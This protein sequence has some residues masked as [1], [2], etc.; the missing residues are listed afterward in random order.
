[1]SK[2]YFSLFGIIFIL[3]ILSCGRNIQNQVVTNNF[4]NEN[5]PMYHTWNS[6]KEMEYEK[7]YFQLPVI[8]PAKGFFPWAGTVSH[9][10]LAHDY[11]DVWFFHLS[12]I[13]DIKNFFILSPDHYNISLEPYSLTIGSW[14]SGFGFVESD[15]D[16]VRQI[17]ELLDVD[18]DPAVFT[19]EH[20]IS[21]L[22]PY[23]KKYFPQA[24]V[25]AI[26]H[27]GESAVNTLL[28]NRLADILENEFD[29]NGKKENFLL[30]SADFS[31]GGNPQTIYLNDINS[32]RYLKGDSNAGWNIVICDNR[33]GIYILDRLGKNNLKSNILYHTNSWEISG[34]GENDITSYFFTFF[35][36]RY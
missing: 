24:K 34:H 29:E 30:I 20:G 26:I 32:A 1:M 9:H 14:E 23:I 7:L 8:N 2:K 19:V 6:L 28:T 3:L 15:R 22:M 21:A 11:I 35:A 25:I 12:Q 18:L 36:D 17:I 33:A 5:I 31:H 27:G 16:K 4:N 13:R 10:I